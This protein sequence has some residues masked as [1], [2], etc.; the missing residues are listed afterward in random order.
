[1]PPEWCAGAAEGGGVLSG[2]Y[3]FN[4]VKRS[5]T[6]GAL[7]RLQS[8][9]NGDFCRRCLA[10]ADDVMIGR[11]DECEGVGHVFTNWEVSRQLSCGSDE[12]HRVMWRL[13]IYI[14]L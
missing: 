10:F 1:M 9:I 7:S 11:W 13:F 3:N 12:G 8:G 2:N 5:W 4:L 6:R 14:Y